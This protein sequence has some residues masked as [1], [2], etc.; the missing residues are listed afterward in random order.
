MKYSP[1][2]QAKIAQAGRYSLIDF[3]IITF[4]NYKPNWH[5]E[6]LAEKLEA[7]ERGEIKRLI[8]EMPPRHGKSELASI[9]F[10]ALFLGKNPEK[11]I[12]ATSYNTELAVEFGGKTRDVILD[13]V[14]QIIFPEGISLKEDEQARGRWRTN[15]GGSYTS[16]GIGGAIT[17]RGANIL[18]IDD[19]I[20]N[21]EEADSKIIRDKH[22]DWYRSTAYTRLEKDGA[23]ILILTRWHMDDLAGRL[24]EEQANGG[25]KWEIL[26][27]PAIATEDEEHRKK[28]EPLWPEKYSVEQLEKIKNTIGMSNWSSLYQQEPILS[29]YQEFK[30]QYI[31]YRTREEVDAMNTRKFLTIDTAYSQKTEADYCGICRN[32]VDRENKWNLSAFRAKLSPYELI[33]LLFKMYNEEKFEK[34]GI[35]KTAYLVGLRPYLEEEQRKRDV[36]LPIVELEHK[37]IN[38]HTRI[39]SLLPRY[40]T[41]SIYHIKGEC[42][43]LEDE[44]FSFPKGLKDDI[45]DATAYQSQIAESPEN[46]YANMAK[47]QEIRRERGVDFGV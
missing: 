12:I 32:Y 16:T 44:M 9:R 6:L 24:L 29:E 2:E 35:E 25:E 26:K 28:G 17:G 13:P 15:K 18:L 23:I 34:M 1:E 7:V 39:R 8:I 27:L 19:P 46:I 31:K 4:P 47:I 41:N 14:Y 11:D 22:W 37:E 10:P 33:N 42:N 38:K 36:F 21:K 45:I 20:K 3:S 5:H 30:P 40:Q 43:D